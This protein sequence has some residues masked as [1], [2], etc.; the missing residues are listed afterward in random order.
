MEVAGKTIR[1]SNTLWVQHGGVKVENQGDAVV[2]EGVDE[3]SYL[4]VFNH[5]GRVLKLYTFENGEWVD[6]ATGS[7][8]ALLDDSLAGHVAATTHV[9]SLAP[10]RAPK[11]AAPAAGR[12]KTAA[13]RKPAKQDGKA[14]AAPAKKTTPKR[15]SGTTA[16]KAKASG[17]S[18]SQA[19]KATTRSKPK[20]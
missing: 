16:G 14:K 11:K 7:A 9:S 17:R 18:G 10:S 20:G 5:F 15:A 6:A 19:A 3:D 4:K 1:F 8:P 2:V 13:T 12:K